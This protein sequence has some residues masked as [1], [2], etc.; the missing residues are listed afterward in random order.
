MSRFKDRDTL[1]A[2]DV[3]IDGE[4]ALRPLGA[5]ESLNGL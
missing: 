3:F 4:S 5:R 1:L 2:A